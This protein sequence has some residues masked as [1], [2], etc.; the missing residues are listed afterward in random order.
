MEQQVYE[1]EAQVEAT[2][3]WF[4]CRREFF[5]AKIKELNL[6]KHSKVLDVGTSTGTNL[7]MLDDLG[8]TNSVGVEMNEVAINFAAEKGFTNIKL[9]DACDLPFDDNTFDL[10][11][12]TDVLEH[13]ENDNDALTE[14]HRVMK[15]NGVFLSTVPAFKK[16]WGL[17]D[18]ISHHKRR[19]TRF[20]LEQKVGAASLNIIQMHYFNFILLIPIWIARR[21]IS[22]LSIRVQSENEINNK[23]VNKILYWV[24]HF[25]CHVAG[26]INPPFGV[27]IFTLCKK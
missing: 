13:I 17:Q 12:A 22:L 11:L 19:Y 18:D 24:F 4:V 16:L 2:H 25:D 26:K 7:R 27:S 5:S 10:V 8:F 1:Y 6:S 3:W 21:L 9:G 15:R 20:E 23:V 14:I